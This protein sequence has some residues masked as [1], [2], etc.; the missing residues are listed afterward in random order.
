MSR[1]HDDEARVRLPR[2][3]SLRAAAYDWLC[4][5]DN[6]A[7][8][9]PHRDRFRASSRE[10]RE[11]VRAKSEARLSAILAH[12]GESTPYYGARWQALGFR[13]GPVVDLLRFQTL[14]FLTKDLIRQEKSA[15]LSNRY[16]AEELQQSVTGGTTGQQTAFFL[17][18]AC[19]ITRIGRQWGALEQCGYAPGM[20]RG[21][22]WG[23]HAELPPVGLRGS[24]KAKFRGYATGDTTLG[25][26]I[27]SDDEM[28]VFYR[29]LSRVR[30][31]VLY[32]YPSGLSEFASFIER[33]GLTPIRVDRVL[34]TAERLTERR[35][36]RLSRAFE[37][38]VFNLYC[39]RE[40]GCIAFECRR[41]Q[42]LHIDSESV[43]VEIV[44][45]GRVVGP[46]EFGEIVITDLNNYGMP[47]IRTRTGDLGALSPTPCPCGLPWP[48]LTSLD[49]RDSDV[50]YRPDGRVVT[51]LMLSDLMIDFP[52]IRAQQ[53]VQERIDAIEVLVEADSELTELDRAEI[54]KE[55]RSLM[56]DE[57]DCRVQVVDQIDRNPLSGKI[58]EVICRIHPAVTAGS[59]SVSEHP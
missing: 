29:R 19:R 26:S 3:S 39:T 46:G 4:H 43:W 34:T 20:R 51:A 48:L 45:D 42:G 11:Q 8:W 59:H 37:A 1:L 14:P 54:I 22:V 24:F 31:P 41:H 35:R 18:R 47:F 57:I 36:E 30:P 12:A 10:T 23:V 2:R 32:G 53:F 49:G 56:G 25:C 38:E 50:V 58:R 21:L 13:P 5:R 9:K 44:R 28:M 15:L 7:G 6:I 17:D 40:Y 33:K 27:L 55:V 52:H 16:R